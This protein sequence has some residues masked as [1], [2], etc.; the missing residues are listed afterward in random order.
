[1]RGRRTFTVS[2]FGGA[3]PTG[4][5]DL[6]AQPSAYDLPT[7]A[8]YVAD[9]VI[10]SADGTLIGRDGD[11]PHGDFATSTILSAF[12]QTVSERILWA[13]TDTIYSMDR[14]TGALA[15][16][17]TGAPVSGDPWAFA[18]APAS[19]G[20]GPT[21]A[22]TPSAARYITDTG[23]SSGVWT[24]SAG[25]LP[26]ARTLLAAGNRL[27]AGGMTA[28]G[29]LA[30]PGSA[31]V[32]SELGDPRNWPV[33]NVVMLDPND[34]Q[35]ITGLGRVG[36]LVIVFKN[37]KTYVVYDLD[38]GAN[39]QLSDSIGCADKQSVISTPYGLVFVSYDN[40]LMVTDGTSIRT[41]GP[42]STEPWHADP[43]SHDVQ[44][45]FWKNRYLA[46][47][48][49]GIR[50]FDFERKAWTTAAVACD[51]LVTFDYPQGSAALWGKLAN[52][53]KYGELMAPYMLDGSFNPV[54]VTTDL[55][56][57][58]IVG[59]YE[60]M[61]NVDDA[62]PHRWREVH[63]VGK[64]NIS[65]TLLDPTTGAALSG[66]AQVT[67]RPGTDSATAITKDIS[68]VHRG[69][70]ARLSIPSHA[71]VN[72]LTAYTTPKAPG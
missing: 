15:T 5:T 27:W 34:G 20:Q 18:S 19:G 41:L 59:S 60:A 17:V 47:T 14:S 4:V 39:R 40:G 44:G 9:D 23:L 56:G 37:R 69:V 38:T 46:A 50:M 36:D 35:F 33:A 11:V 30:D 3:I 55:E 12:A 21:Y 29:G 65:F 70:L 1:V 42:V 16:V 63:A 54:P 45:A 71:E 22:V 31:L 13:G 43:R 68:G 62:A 51:V 53:T 72:A 57:V 48:A 25:S 10:L 24:A 52:D 2:G 6:S 61:L 66:A 32:W 28:Y 8:A 49:E 26:L 64:G 67:R 7:G 58:P